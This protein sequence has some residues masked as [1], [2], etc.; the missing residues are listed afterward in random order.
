MDTIAILGIGAMGA[1]MAARL[2]CAG[3]SVTVYN[4]TPSRCEPLVEQGAT[5]AA[6]PREAASKAD[7]VISMV[8]D[9]AASRAVWF[10]PQTGALAGLRAGALAIES[11]TLTPAWIAELGAALGQ[12]GVELLDAPVAGSRPQ[13]EAGALIYLV[14]GSPESLDRARP[15]L[16]HMGGKIVH[17]G[18]RG[19]GANL[20]LAVNA[21]FAI[22]VAAFAE[23]AAMLERAGFERGAAIEMLAAMPVTSPAVAG[24]A[25]LIAAEAYAPLF[26]VELVE[27][28]LDYGAKTA[29]A[30]GGE[31][32]MTA[33][34]REVY[35]R[36]LASGWGSEN[37]HAIAKLHAS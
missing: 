30:S 3:H 25:K 11:S 12:R 17:A 9:D 18:P 27:K 7:V 32:P 23:L 5:L 35:A 31:A 16:E 33:A 14:G 13:A 36:A 37:I 15:L 28:D 29:S 1:R 8:R 20:K 10:D 19:A 4:R 26:P 6:S 24:V 22:G 21:S 2:L 34:A